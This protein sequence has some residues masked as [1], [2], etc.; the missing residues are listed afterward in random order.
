[1]LYR[2]NFDYILKYLFL[3]TKPYQYFQDQTTMMMA[4]PSLTTSFQVQ[5]FLKY[6]NQRQNLNIGSSKVYAYWADL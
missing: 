1:M 6:L 3:K 5:E 4:H 2:D